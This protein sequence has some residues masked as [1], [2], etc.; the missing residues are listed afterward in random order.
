MIYNNHDILYIDSVFLTNMLN[1]TQL[2]FYYFVQLPVLLY[3]LEYSTCG[4]KR[5]VCQ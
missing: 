3:P 1:N 4:M 2:L 5:L